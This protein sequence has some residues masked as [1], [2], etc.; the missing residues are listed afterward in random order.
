MNG[1]PAANEKQ[2]EDFVIEVDPPTEPQRPDGSSVYPVRVTVAPTGS[3]S[4]R[5]MVLRMDDRFRK[6]LVLVRS[7][8]FTLDLRREFGYVLFKALFEGE[9]RD[10]WIGSQNRIAGG[11]ADGLRL[12]L[13]IRAS[14]LAALPWELLYQDDTSR[15]LATNANQV[16]AR[17]LPV[18]EPLYLP[19]QERLRILL[20]VASP[21]NKPVD[22]NEIDHL[23][24]SIG[25]LGKELVELTVLRDR[26]Y[27]AILSELQRADYHVLHYL[28]HGSSGELHLTDEGG[29]KTKPLHAQDFAELVAG[30]R[31]LRLV[32]LNACAS[33][34]EETGGLFSGVGPVLVQRGIPAVIAMQY[35]F[36]LA[37][38][39]GRFSEG[40]YRALA[41]GRPVDVAVNEARKHLIVEYSADDREWSAPVLYLGTRKSRILTFHRGDAEALKLALEDAAREA[42]SARSSLHEVAQH[43][44]QVALSPGRL[45]QWLALESLLGQ[46]QIDLDVLVNQAKE[47]KNRLAQEA[48]QLEKKLDDPEFLKSLV[49]DLE[50]GRLNDL[51]RA[52]KY[53]ICQDLAKLKSEVDGAGEI[54]QDWIVKL[55]ELRAE[56]N[57]ALVVSID[58]VERQCAGLFNYVREQGVYCR[59]QIEQEVSDLGEWTIRLRSVLK[60]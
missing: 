26:P 3:S 24:Q 41:N 37:E 48:K 13:S 47:G 21:K 14:E 25:A 7:M 45:D 56:V 53:Q 36:V 29:T 30:R 28:G 12:C 8:D 57:R 46:L 11:E 58:E 4:P 9:V 31:T 19:A 35:G 33:S 43:V 6:S 42:E 38:S 27:P 10:K 18:G 16:L 54:G 40:F 5:Q 59:K 50:Q 23:E 22:P 60:A 51:E 44:R 34:Q 15:F 55:D 39:A 52:W 20:V 32:V 2:Y 49:A 17:Y 1:S